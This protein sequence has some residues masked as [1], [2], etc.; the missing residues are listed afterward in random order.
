[1]CHRDPVLV[2]IMNTIHQNGRSVTTTTT[3]NTITTTTAAA[4]YSS[5]SNNQLSLIRMLA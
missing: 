2:E 5:N 3:T 1:M 4:A